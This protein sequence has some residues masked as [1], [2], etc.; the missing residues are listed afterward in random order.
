[1]STGALVSRALWLNQLSPTTG[2]SAFKPL[3]NASR[4]RNARLGLTGAM[5]FD[6]ERFCHWLEGS[7]HGMQTVRQE[8]EDDPRQAGLHVLYASSV[9][10]P[11]RLLGWS[12]GFCDATDLDVFAGTSGLQGDD[13]LDAFFALLARCDLSP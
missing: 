9:P 6:G 5:L 1:M 4:Q 12:S 7:P 13:A 8:L 11:R 3:M 10:G 2:F